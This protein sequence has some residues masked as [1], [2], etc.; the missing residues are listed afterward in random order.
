V[1]DSKGAA[2]TQALS[3]TVAPDVPLAVK[4]TKLAKASENAPYAATLAGTGG[5]APYTWA[6]SGGALPA[7][8]TLG[9]NGQF[10]GQPAA[11]GTFTFTV[12]VTDSTA[13]AETASKSLSLVVKPA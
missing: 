10:V 11:A 7:G 6:I 5:T 12:R 1:H 3:M 4:T 8:L 9:S 13:P 2:A